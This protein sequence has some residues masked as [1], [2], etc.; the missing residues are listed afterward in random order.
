MNKRANFRALLLLLTVAVSTLGSLGAQDAVA[1]APPVSAI[2]SEMMRLPVT[3]DGNAFVLETR[4]LTAPGSGSKPLAV[5][6][7]GS[8]RKA[9][10]RKSMTTHQYHFR[11]MEFARRGYVTAVVMRRGYGKS[12]AAWFE[13]Y[14]RCNSPDYISAGFNTAKD[15][16]AAVRA[17]KA[18]IS[19][20]HNRVLVVGQSAG[21]FGSVAL[22]AAN[23]PG[24]VAT[25]NFAGGRGSLRSG[26]VCGGNK[27]VQAFGHFGRTARAPS[28]WVYAQNDQYF[29]PELSRMFHRTYTSAGGSADFVMTGPFGK[30]GHRLFSRDGIAQWR[31]IV[32]RFLR[33]V[34]LPT[35]K[36][37]PPLPR[38][39]DVH[40]PAGL[41]NRAQRAWRKY[42]ASP[43]N[44]AF[45][46]SKNGSR[47]GWRTSRNSV[48]DAS[49]DALRYC[50]A[51]DCIV[52]ST[53]GSVPRP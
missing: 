21:G 16:A 3:I 23:P 5:I 36:V 9:S 25:I 14:G 8:P 53:N 22:A 33:Q 7:H 52:V 49:N 4:V 39:P 29:G 40:A 11:A 2:R 12:N 30:D 10:S 17:L 31:P 46:R 48:A 32:D 43:N 15:I 24:L 45:A 35:W 44:K 13:T 20:D 28:L 27:L 50:R 38:T 26:Q 42:L 34:G 51:S 19:F 47:F 37:A 6:N 1:A 41:S 18:R